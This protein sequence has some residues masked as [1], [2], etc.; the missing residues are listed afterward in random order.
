MLLFLAGA[1]TVLGPSLIAWAWMI[2]VSR[3]DEP[4]GSNAQIVPFA[5]PYPKH[6]LGIAQALEPPTAG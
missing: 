2:W 6:S 5:R 3:E 4:S 1:L